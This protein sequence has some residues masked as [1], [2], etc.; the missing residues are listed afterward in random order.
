MCKMGCKISTIEWNV[1]ENYNI[2]YYFNLLKCSLCHLLHFYK[3]LIKPI[4]KCVQFI[5]VLGN[6][7]LEIFA[8]S[9]NLSYKFV[10]ILSLNH[11]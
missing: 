1:I 7:R 3:N 9:N 6:V 2:D 11:V 10:L 5:A 4:T 8:L